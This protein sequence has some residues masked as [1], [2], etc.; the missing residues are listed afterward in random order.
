MKI[1]KSIKTALNRLNSHGY[2]AYIVGGALRDMLLH[3]R[4][5]DYDITTNAY[6][7][8]IKMIFNDYISYDIGKKHGTVVVIIDKDKIDITPYRSENKYLDHRHPSE[9]RFTNNLK[10][11]L[12]RRDFTINAMC[13]DIDENIIDYF[14]G[15]DDLNNR[16][17]KTVGRPENR[18]S[19]DALR[20]LRAIRFKAQ[21]CFE[22]EEKTDAEIHRLKDLLKYIS[23]E[24]KKEEL[25]HILNFK[26]AF[27]II[28]QYLDVINTFMSF[29][30]IKRKNNNFSNPLYALAYLLKDIDNINLKS[31]K[32]SN[33]EI[34]LIRTLIEATKTDL[35]DD[36]DFIELLSSQYQNDIL[37]FLNEYHHRNYNERFN[38]LK[39]YMIDINTL[40]INGTQIREY[41]YD[42]ENI[43]TVKKHLLDLIHHQRLSNNEK[44]LRNYLKN[45]IIK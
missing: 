26:S 40:K 35:K 34:N 12:R 13:M 28:N 15:L 29:L 20:I 14:D 41:G 36:Y 3:K 5:S 44:S 32:Y 37:K 17:I 33:N 31:L 23:E 38:K 19:E 43:S 16:I 11:D 27:S 2:D 18:F 4:V 22:I 30:P 9:I 1:K 21:L 6:P 8:A 10:E 25:L 24:R 7:E 39:K 42:D 45:H